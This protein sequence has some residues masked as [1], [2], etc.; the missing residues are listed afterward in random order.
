MSKIEQI[1]ER[2]AIIAERQRVERIE[3]GIKLRA[4]WDRRNARRPST[5]AATHP[6]RNM[7]SVPA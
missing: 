5:P 7:R 6:W 4:A 3:E 2:I 1:K